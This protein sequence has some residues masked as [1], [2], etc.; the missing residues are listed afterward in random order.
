MPGQYTGHQRQSRLDARLKQKVSGPS[1]NYRRSSERLLNTTPP[2]EGILTQSRSSR[3]H[4]FTD[5]LISWKAPH[6]MGQKGWTYM[7]KFFLGTEDY[8][9]RIAKLDYVTNEGSAVVNYKGAEIVVP[10]GL[11]IMI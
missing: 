8:S 11:W 9:H 10:H 4:L 7:V 6:A 1:K 2:P 5:L 3:L